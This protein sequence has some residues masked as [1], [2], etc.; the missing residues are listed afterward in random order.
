VLRSGNR[1][2]FALGYVSWAICLQRRRRSSLGR[3]NDVPASSFCTTALHFNRTSSPTPNIDNYRAIIIFRGSFNNVTRNH[4][5]ISNTY[6]EPE[7]RLMYRR[8]FG[9]IFLACIDAVQGP[10]P[11]TPQVTTRRPLSRVLYNFALDAQLSTRSQLLSSSSST[12]SDP[13]DLRV[14][15]S[16]P[17][18]I[19]S[20]GSALSGVLR[21]H[22]TV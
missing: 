22:N 8:L 20:P 9:A 10:S 1:T 11:S 14:H 2:M 5:S 3:C 17:P 4:V 7:L 15:A 19:D 21:G 16:H 18:T 13:G 6:P 12:R